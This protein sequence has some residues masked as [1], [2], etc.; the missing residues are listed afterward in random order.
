MSATFSYAQAA[1][2]VSGT[3]VPSK[4][5]S[6]ESEKSEPK[7][8]EPSDSVPAAESVTTVSET[9]TP[10]EPETTTTSVDKEAEF[11]TVTSK[12]AHRSKANNSRTSSPSVRSTAAQSKDGDASN[13]TNGNADASSEKQSQPD[14]KADKSENGSEASKEKSE[15]SEKA[16]PP[17]ELKAAPL[18]SV[19]IWQQRKEAQEA[20]AKTTPAPAAGKGK[21]EE[22]QQDS[23]KA[24]SKKKGADGASEGTKGKKTDGKGRDE[25]LPPVADAS[26]W[27]TPQVALGEE[28]KKAQEKT[29]KIERTDKSPVA[30]SHG[31]EKW[32]PVNY[33]PTAVFNTPLPSASSGRGGRR[34]ARGGR[35]SGRGGAHGGGAAAGEKAASGHTPQASAAKQGSGE[36]GRN[37]AG[38]GRAASLPAQSRRSNS[39]DVAN[40]DARKGQATDRGRGARGGED[41]ATNG[42]Q[43]T[44]GEHSSRPQ[45]DGK[46]F[47][48]N[49]DARAGDRNSKGAH[50]AVDSQAAARVNDRRAESGPKSAD[51]NRD[52]TGPQDFN[53]E[54]GDSRAERGGRNANRSRGPYSNFGQ[55]P[56]F[57][58][59]NTFVP[60]KFGF[61]DRQ[62]SQHGVQNGQQQN[63]RMPLRSP[64]LPASAGMYG[65]VYPFPAEIN[66][67][68]PY[69]NVAPGP[70]SAVPY[71]Q[72]MEPFGLMTMLSMQLEYYFSVD[73][74]CKDMFLRRHM[75]SQGFVPLGVIA[76]FKRVKSLTEDFEMLRHVS[77]SLRNVDYQ[78]G[79]DGVDRLRPKER[80]AQWVLPVDQRDPSAQHEGA[81]PAKHSGK[82]DENVPFNNHVDSATNGANHNGPRQFVPNGAASRGSRTPLSSAAP[83]FQPAQNEIANVG[84][85]P[86][87]F[88]FSE[89][90]LQS[91]VSFS[92]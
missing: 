61:N 2:G 31:K 23:G 28:K 14:A 90:S 60:G 49:Q 69:Q 57:S 6:T 10:Q 86:D 78:I 20:K 66:T 71:Q 77:R 89:G 85:T 39:A 56:Q 3:P 62:R 35:D 87:S 13:T 24:G 58:M 70:M 19:N 82:I 42:K 43:V 53:R 91:T 15:K 92:H 9:E 65:N 80:W 76:S 25:N 7:A 8:E 46:Q 84:T 48:R 45:R 51:M 44:S 72:Y 37:E 1:K 40:P 88:P 32:M 38:T 68:Y 74:M 16:A 12:H 29:E 63:N 79:E 30:R 41:V 17:K 21:S 52:S 67:M 33:V 26:S 55:N 50:L 27:P 36:R 73:N 75:D 83:E 81:P 64:S 11:T 54:R 34:A 47:T 59:A 5:G 4:A 22:G 18:P